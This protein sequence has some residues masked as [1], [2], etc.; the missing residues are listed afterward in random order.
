MIR[1][2]R[3]ANVMGGRAILR[4]RVHSIRDL[5]RTV[6]R[7]LPKRALRSTVERV[8]TNKAD[9]RRVMFRLVPEATFKRRV[10]LSPAESERTERLA[11]VIAAAEY[12]WNNQADAREWLAKRHPELGRRSPLETAMTELGARQVE[13]LLDRLV[14]G[15]PA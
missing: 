7:G 2:D 10:R 8:L 14:Y 12:A 15:I 11:R 3:I 6:A 9:V 1:P 13:E 5:E 4:R